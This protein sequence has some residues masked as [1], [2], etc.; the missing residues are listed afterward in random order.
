MG[1]Q[2]ATDVEAAAEIV[3]QEAPEV[4]DNIA[5][6]SLAGLLNKPTLK[7][8]SSKDIVEFLDKYDLYSGNLPEGQALS[9]KTCVGAKT[10]RAIERMAMARD[11]LDDRDDDLPLGMSDRDIRHLLEHCATSITV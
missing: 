8:A 7:S 10:W 2:L 4:A 6:T 3:Q 9:I 5:A 11:F 1:D